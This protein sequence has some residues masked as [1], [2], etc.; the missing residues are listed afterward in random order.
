[1]VPVKYQSISIPRTCIFYILYT[2]RTYCMGK[3]QRNA[4]PAPT[5][6]EHLHPLRQ[7]MWKW[8]SR[9]FIL[10]LNGHSSI[11]NTKF[12][13]SLRQSPTKQLEQNEKIWWIPSPPPQCCA[14]QPSPILSQHWKG[15]RGLFHLLLSGIV[16]PL[17]KIWRF[18]G[19]IGNRGIDLKRMV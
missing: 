19:K 5:P 7:I 15:E 4:C 8:T 14:T 18:N 1:M 9:L 17:Y 3:H 6:H 11:E 16:Y 10:F 2:N 12:V 13:Q